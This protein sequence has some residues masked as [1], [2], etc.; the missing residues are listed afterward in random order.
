MKLNRWMK[1]LVSFYNRSHGKVF[2]EIWKYPE[3]RQPRGNAW[4]WGRLSQKSG[5]SMDYKVTLTNPAREQLEQIIYYL[6]HEL[7][8]AQVANSVLEDAANTK[9]RLSHV[10]G[11]LKLCENIKLKVLGYQ[12]YENIF[13]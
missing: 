2:I 12:D 5:K 1:Q 8:N 7:G 3:N 11:S 6:L 9:L 4:T 13:Q 10:A